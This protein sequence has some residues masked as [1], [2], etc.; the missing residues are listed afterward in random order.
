MTDDRDDELARAQLAVQQTHQALLDAIKSRLPQLEELLR[1]MGH[2]YEDR[3]YRFYY[4]SF[5]VYYLQ[6]ATA[7]AAGMFHEIGLAAGRRPN[8]WF[9][10]I[11]AGGTGREFELSHNDDWLRHTR[12][13]VEAF[14]HAKYF[15]EMMV[16][17][18]RE[19]DVAP[20]ALPSGWAALLTL[21]ELR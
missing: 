10:E 16:K 13:V 19:L 3:L 2:A 4:Q 8:P 17:Y 20:C 11:V 21:Y 18:G 14:L 1:V 7:Y 6:Q 15:V 5:K 12:P 9:E